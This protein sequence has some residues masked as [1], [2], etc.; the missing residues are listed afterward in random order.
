M[1]LQNV[2]D[3]YVL[4]SMQ[5]GILFHMLYEEQAHI[6]FSQFVCTIEQPLDIAIFRQ[7]W[8]HM[9]TRHS[10]LRTAFLWDGLDEPLQVVRRQVELPWEYLDWRG[11]PE[12]EQKT[13]LTAFLADDR[14][15]GFDLTIAPLWRLYLIQT[16]EQTCTFI[17]SSPHLLMDG[18]SRALLL[19]EVSTYYNACVRGQT[20]RLP[21]VRAYR[22]YIAWLQRQD[23]ARAENYWRET[24]KGFTE[25]LTLGKAPATTEIS[26][27]EKTSHY[28]RSEFRLSAEL[29]A[30]LQT[31]TRQQ[32]VTLNTLLQGAWAILL[33]R[34]SN[35]QDIVFG[36]TVAG[37]PTSLP[38]SETMV[39]LF[40]NTLPLRVDVSP[41]ARLTSW[42]KCLQEQQS[43]ML[44]YQY[45][46]LVQ[47]RGW[48]DI[49][50]DQQLFESILVFENTLNAV[51]WTPTDEL[52]FRNMR[53]GVEHTNYPLTLTVGPDS[54]LLLRFAYDANR[55]ES[56]EIASIFEHLRNLLAHMVTSPTAHLSE[57]ALLSPEERKMILI[58]WNSTQQDYPTGQSMLE[59]FEEQVRKS[60]DAIAVVYEEEQVSY[61]DLLQRSLLLARYLRSLGVLPEQRVGLCL[62]PSASL[63]LAVL[64][65]LFSGAAYVPLDPAAPPA[66]LS[67]LLQDAHIAIL[68]THHALQ[69]LFASSPVQLLF[70]DLDWLSL[71]PSPLPP[72]PP[73]TSASSVAYVLYTSGS[74]GQ[75]KGVLVEHRAL[76]N[77][78]L[79]IQ[80]H[81]ALSP[82]GV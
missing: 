47:V 29:T 3:I 62:P 19:Q 67:F 4:G 45:T 81:L 52:Q 71:L 14:A 61:Q 53:G 18:W 40:I 10:T 11:I 15:R 44:E 12:A 70:L 69:P 17:S 54:E 64:A 51:S 35:T 68:L 76:L 43:A 79:A 48:S 50:H 2:E 60:P 59:L 24:L 74:T 56:Q 7:A 36:V 22:D 55:F 27:D 77:Y 23:L 1:K 73:S 37:R 20:P 32:Q 72:L 9:L 16:T 25:P 66:R 82:A 8:Q 6:Y 49:P 28:A 38:G 58:D 39:G 33:S 13:R 42:L 57:F 31:F 41:D 78:L 63:V 75:P 80:Q 34:Y 30:A 46:P 65:V 21:R 5:Q 26:G